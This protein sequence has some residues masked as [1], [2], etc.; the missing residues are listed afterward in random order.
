MKPAALKKLLYWVEEREQM[1]LRRER[2]GDAPYTIDLILAKYRFCNVRR[3]DDRVT[4][5]IRDHIRGPF[6]NHPHLWFML[7]I[8][9]QINWPPTLRALINSKGWPEDDEWRWPE[10]VSVMN[11]MK[12]RGEQVYTG[13]YMVRGPSQKG[14]AKAFWTMHNVLLPLWDERYLMGE[15]L[16]DNPTLQGTT[17][18]LQE[19]QGWGPFMSYQAVVDMR[20]TRLLE[21]APDRLTWAAAG[22]GTIRGLNRLYGRKV[23]APLSQEQAVKEL[24]V[25]YPLVN[26]VVGCDFSD[27]PNVC[28]EFD[29]YERA[30][31]GEGKPRSLYKPE[32]RF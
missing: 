2:G 12:K 29:K 19:Y 30:R 26:K 10:A 6:S 21:N 32:T 16:T 14:I 24:R 7:C 18:G 4:G 31:L 3:E 27:I 1:R 8:A 20:F 22:P 23:D 5:W 28:C 25:L 13:A 9:R 15:N 11:S 17:E